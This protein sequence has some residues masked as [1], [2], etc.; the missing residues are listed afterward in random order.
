MIELRSAAKRFG[1]TVAL[2]PCDLTVAA[3]A[4][5]VLIGPSGCGKSTCLRLMVGLIRPDS[6][7]VRFE[8]AV[9]T[10]ENLG[11]LRLRMGFV[12]QDGGL[13]PH[14]TA[15][16][17]VTLMA[18]HLGWSAGKIADRL[19]YLQTLGK[20]PEGALGRFPH[21]LSGG[22]RQRLSL[23]R[24]LLLDPPLLLL[25]EP[26]GALDPMIRTELQTDC[27]EIF[28]TLGKTVVLV[29]HDLGEAGFFADRIVLFRAGSIV[30]QGSLRELV[31]S[32]A[33]E[34]VT[35]FIKAQRSPLESLLT[36]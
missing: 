7:E 9:L 22:Q 20:L 19:D 36:T 30:Q 33:N 31:E 8:G 6:G 12:I 5:T 3:G 1:T 23:L 17:N 27:K 24:A 4:T 16:D 28:K 25:D 14:L 34:F 2:A 15:R 13:F 11:A 32:P 26:L 35:R 10:D 21:E 18:R 29:T